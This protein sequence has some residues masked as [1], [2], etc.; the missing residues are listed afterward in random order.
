MD[1]SIMAEICVYSGHSKAENLRT[2]R[3]VKCWLRSAICSSGA[4]IP[5]TPPYLFIPCDGLEKGCGDQR[6]MLGVL[7]LCA[8][9]PL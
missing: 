8:S 7:L 3:T 9:L 5:I 2:G 6:C 4:L 1:G